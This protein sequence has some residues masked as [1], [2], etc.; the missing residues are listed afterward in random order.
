MIKG[1]NRG[2]ETRVVWHYSWFQS[3]DGWNATSSLRFIEEIQEGGG[4]E[5]AC[6]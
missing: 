2:Q 5:L 6:I 1:H 3:Q 4:I